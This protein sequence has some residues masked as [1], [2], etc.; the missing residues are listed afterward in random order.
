LARDFGELLNNGAYL[1]SL[2]I[3]DIGNFSLNEAFTLD[4][5]A[6]TFGEDLSRRQKK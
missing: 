3:T 2:C 6:E 1:D 5:L 4:E